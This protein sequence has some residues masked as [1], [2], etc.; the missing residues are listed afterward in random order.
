MP[1]PASPMICSAALSCGPQSHFSDPNTS[2]VR[3]SLCSRTSGGLPPDAPISSATCSCPSSGARKATICVGGMSSSGSLARATIST[4]G[5]ARLAHDVGER[6][7]QLGGFGDRAATSAGSSPAERASVERR[8]GSSRRIR[9]RPDEAARSGRD[10][11]RGPDRRARAPSAAS[12]QVRA[13]DQH[14]RAGSAASRWLASFSVAARSPLISSRARCSGSTQVEQ[15]LASR[16]RPPAIAMS[17]WRRRS[18]PAARRAARRSRGRIARRSLKPRTRRSAGRG[19]TAAPSC[20]TARAPRAPST[21][22][23]SSGEAHIWSSRRPRSFLVQS[24]ER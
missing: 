20:G 19:R 10:R 16:S 8:A 3:H 17:A 23:A 2:P 24:G 9:A 7:A 22:P 4:D 11:G 1:P 6:D 21:W 15:L 5:C 14:R 12:S 18:A 13:L